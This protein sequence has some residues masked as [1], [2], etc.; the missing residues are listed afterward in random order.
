[1]EIVRQRKG[2]CLESKERPVNE[3]NSRGE[4]RMTSR[5]E[6]LEERNQENA[7]EKAGTKL[8]MLDYWQEYNFERD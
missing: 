6:G 7:G 4:M 5:T 3:N 8:E 1:M 2:K